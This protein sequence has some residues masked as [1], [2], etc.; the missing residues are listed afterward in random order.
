MTPSEFTYSLNNVGADFARL[1]AKP[2]RANKAVVGGRPG[3]CI[4]Q[5]A[6]TCNIILGAAI[7]AGIATP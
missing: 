7:R 2:R 4:T 3:A 6:Q 5:Q 1:S